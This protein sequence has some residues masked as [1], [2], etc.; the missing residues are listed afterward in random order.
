VEH[1]KG[2]LKVVPNYRGEKILL[3]ADFHDKAIGESKSVASITNDIHGELKLREAN[4]EHLAKCW[5]SHDTLLAV[6]NEVSEMV[7]GEPMNTVT[8]QR[9]KQAKAKAK[10]A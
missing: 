6:C 5:N 9:A 3:K 2:K 8:L 1:T 10:R 7:A 4:A